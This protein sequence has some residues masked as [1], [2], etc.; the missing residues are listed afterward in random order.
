MSQPA[1]AAA[2]NVFVSSHAAV[3][4]SASAAHPSWV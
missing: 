1:A 3:D 4:A 2:A